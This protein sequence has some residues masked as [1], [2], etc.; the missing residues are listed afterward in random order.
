MSQSD[1]SIAKPYAY[2]AFSFAKASDSLPIWGEWLKALADIVTSN[3]A[4]MLLISPDLSSEQRCDFLIGLLLDLSSKKSNS[5]I[6]KPDQHITN[7]IKL[8]VSNKRQLE[9]DSIFS[10]YQELL[11]ELQHQVSVELYAVDS[12]EKTQLTKLQQ[13]LESS[14]NKKVKLEVILDPSLIAGYKIKIGDEVIDS[15]IKNRLRNLAYDLLS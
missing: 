4:R 1:S 12:L 3:N 9:L 13:S 2:A 11:V 5:H 10:S 7:F 6:Q 14:L 15:S 8:V